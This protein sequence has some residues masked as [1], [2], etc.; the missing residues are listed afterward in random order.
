MQILSDLSAGKIAVLFTSPERLISK[1]FLAAMEKISE[2]SEIAF[3][4][5]D[6]AH[7]ISEW[8]HSFRPSYQNAGDILRNR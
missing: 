1:Q 8:G 6:E 4:C 5:V 2:Y 3:A 7:C